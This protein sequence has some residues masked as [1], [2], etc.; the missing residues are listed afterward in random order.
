LQRVDGS[1]YSQPVVRANYLLLSP[2]NAK[3]K[4]MALDP[5]SGAERWSFP[6]REE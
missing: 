2:H 5:E 3:V 6:Q 1:I 4:I